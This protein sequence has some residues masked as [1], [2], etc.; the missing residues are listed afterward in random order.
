MISIPQNNNLFFKGVFFD[1]IESLEDKLYNLAC[2]NSEKTDYTCET[3]VELK[4]KVTY[5]KI[6]AKFYNIKQWVESTKNIK[7][8][9]WYCES[10]FIGVPIFIPSYISNTC[11]GKVFDTYGAFCGWGCAYSHIQDY[12]EYTKT[13]TIW[14]KDH[15]LKMLYKL[16]YNKKIDDFLRIPNKFTTEVYGGNMSM[17]DFKK[18]L[19]KIN[20]QN[21]NNGYN[22]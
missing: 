22:T 16:F 5:D 8:K 13:N 18:E 20:Q 2:S 1:E 10:V 15:M 6:P 4:K 19:K 3:Q 12:S 14:E 11:K 17:T 9:C 21:I 7:I